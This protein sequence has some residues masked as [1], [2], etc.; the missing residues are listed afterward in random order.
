MPTT[1]ARRGFTRVA[2]G[3]AADITTSV[4]PFID[5]VDAQMG[6]VEQG[7][8]AARPGAGKDGDI[9]I[10]RDDRT[11]GPYGTMYWW[12]SA[13]NAWRL[14]SQQ[15]FPGDLKASLQVADHAGWLLADGRSVLRT[16]YPDLFALI[17]TTFGAADGTHFTLPDYRG[18]G[19][20]GKGT[21]ADVDALTDND[22]LA[23]AS[24][25]PKHFHYSPW[26]F[27]EN[28]GGGNFLNAIRSGAAAFARMGY[29]IRDRIT[30]NSLNEGMTPIGKLNGVPGD[31]SS[32]M[33][34]SG[35]AFNGGV[36]S[37][38]AAY[39]DVSGS[40]QTAAYG[41]ANIF[42]KI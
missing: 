33:V 10:A 42:I 32:A 7:T 31:G 37:D 20:V 29:A 25:T 16:D 12:D 34:N 30:D 23:V 15:Q 27:A 18:R 38:I 6:S 14:S 3:D 8:L 35:Y 22:G 21:H 5:Q 28:G 36:Y 41:V 2:L 39:R 1:T 40:T 13:N 4:G 26:P 17:G 24:R 19:I 11:L 9:Y